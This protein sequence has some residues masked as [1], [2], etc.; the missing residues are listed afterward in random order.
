MSKQEKEILCYVQT[1]HVGKTI[2]NDRTQIINPMTGHNLE[3]DVYLPEIS[4]AIEYNGSYWHSDDNTKYKD[5]Q[6]VLQCKEKGIDLL[7]INEENWIVE[8]EACLKK[9]NCFI[10]NTE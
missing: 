4:K 10:N 7:V 5:E 6:K 9:I 8:K 1:I 2:P 3:L